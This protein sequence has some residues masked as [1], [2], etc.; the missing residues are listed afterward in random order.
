MRNYGSRKLWE[1]F[2]KEQL[3]EEKLKTSALHVRKEFTPRG[4]GFSV[5]VNGNIQIRFNE[6]ESDQ[7]LR[8]RPGKYRCSVKEDDVRRQDR[9][10]SN[11]VHFVLNRTETVELQFRLEDEMLR[12]ELV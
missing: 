12:L 1:K 3:E 8:L 6:S 2:D 7:I 10:T 5:Y 4:V 11:E 9:L